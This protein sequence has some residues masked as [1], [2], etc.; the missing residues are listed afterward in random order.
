VLWNLLSN[1]IKFTREGNAIHVRVRHSDTHVEVAVAD[2]GKGISAEF[3]PYVFERFRQA[4]SSI[5]RAHGGLGL[6]LAIVKQL[7]ELHG[8]TVSATSSGEDHGS[9]FTVALPRLR[10]VG[11]HGQAR[12]AQTQ[13]GAKQAAATMSLKGLRLGVIDDEPDTRDWIERV[14][15]D[16][17][18][19]VAAWSNA[20]DLMEQLGGFA[21]D[22][23]ICDIGMP[24]MDG[25][26]LMR[27]IRRMPGGAGATPS[28]AL[29]AFARAED[30]ARALAAGYQLHLGKPV[31]EANLVA[32]VASLANPAVPAA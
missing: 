2:S 31:D 1:A 4:D 21:P 9:T 10:R 5:T 24:D 27:E 11:E 16:R 17:G 12:P 22:V 14:L 8:G 25:Y 7:V 32:A 23:L 18:C 13:A 30:R 6:G 15:V 28:I 29:T 3:L 20:A 26:A 19:E